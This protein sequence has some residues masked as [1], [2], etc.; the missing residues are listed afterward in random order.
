MALRLVDSKLE[1]LPTSLDSWEVL[2]KI[3]FEVEGGK[4]G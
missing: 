2:A 4:G 1:A 3:L